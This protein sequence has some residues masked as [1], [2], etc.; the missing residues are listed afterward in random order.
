MELKHFWK[1]KQM[2]WTI[3]YLY[4]YATPDTQKTFLQPLDPVYYTLCPKKA[5]WADTVFF[6]QGTFEG[7]VWFQIQCVSFT[8]L[9]IQNPKR[10]LIPQSFS[11]N[12]FVLH[13]VGS[14]RLLE[15]TWVPWGSLRFLWYGIQ[16]LDLWFFNYCEL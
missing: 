4:F 9:I 16:C 11:F 5:T 12:F 13:G 7:S 1:F 14:F 2:I 6:E 10:S 3:E 15:V 8:T